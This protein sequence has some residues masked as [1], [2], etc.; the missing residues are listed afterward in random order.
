MKKLE[1]NPA[2]AKQSA[3]DRSKR[4][5]ISG[6]LAILDD[7]LNPTELPMYCRISRLLNRKKHTI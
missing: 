2:T 6:S 1:N 4:S 3:D 7:E 5:K